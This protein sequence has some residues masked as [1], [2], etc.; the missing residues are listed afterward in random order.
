MKKLHVNLLSDEKEHFLP[1]DTVQGLAMLSTTSSVK[2]SC[3]KIHFTGLVSTK[4]AKAQEQAYVIN[5]QVVLAGNANNESEYIIKD[6]KHSWPFE[7]QIPL[8]HIP[9]SGKYRHG[10]IKYT[11]AAIMTSPG[12]M[13][14]MQETKATKVIQIRDLINVKAEPYSDPIIVKGSSNLKPNS[15][16][17]KHYATATVKLSRSAYLKGQQLHV[18]IDLY[19]PNKIR[20]SPGCFFQLIRKESYHAG[21]NAKDFTEKVVTSAEELAVSKSLSTGKITTD[22]TIP[23]SV[24]STLLGAKIM[25][26]EYRLVILF[27]MRSKT[28]FMEGRHSKK[29]KPRMRNKLLSSPG[30]FE[31]EV[32]VFIG[33]VSDDVHSQ[34]L[35]SLYQASIVPRHPSTS[36]SSSSPIVASSTAKSL[37]SLSSSSQPSPSFAHA[38][39]PELPGYMHGHAEARSNP[40][41]S[42][43]AKP[44]PARRQVSDTPQVW[45]PLDSASYSYPRSRSYSASPSF[46]LPLYPPSSSSGPSSQ[47]FPI[48]LD[49]KI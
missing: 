6:G 3:I 25:T 11:I 21:E 9:S 29:V 46:G 23:D 41:L 48:P 7:F 1:G 43:G 45:A 19:H 5:Q 39:A 37:S 15:D 47:S 14:G 8:Q 20:R 35:G 38:S 13:G 42:Y 2:Y 24:I 16:A 10:T 40:P 49:V 32:P 34:R 36:S 4:I 26:V 18:E 28:G 30:G 44:A 31:I 33:T 12:F 22:L 17:P 27:D